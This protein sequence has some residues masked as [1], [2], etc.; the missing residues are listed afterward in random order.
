MDEIF[1]HALKLHIGL[2]DTTLKG[3]EELRDKAKDEL[4]EGQFINAIEEIKSAREEFLL[5]LRVLERAN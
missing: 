2:I 5:E 3:I 4:S 1:I